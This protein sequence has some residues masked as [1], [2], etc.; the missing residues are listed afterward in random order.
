MKNM[1][2]RK[3]RKTKKNIIILIFL[4]SVIVIPSSLG[5]FKNSASITSPITAS[6]WNVSV[7]S[8]SNSS[9]QLVPNSGTASYDI[10]VT[11]SSEVDTDYSIIV[12]NIPSG[13]Q[14]KLDNNEYEPYSSTVTFSNVGTILYGDQYNYKTHI[15][16]FKANTGAT[17]VNN[18][19][20]SVDV[21]FK[22]SL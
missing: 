13:V 7:N 15:L 8:S 12:S 17:L 18:Q 5:I 3:T 10:V 16:T 20:V 22:Q 19:Q 4:L 11:S 21:E 14:V 2:T 6:S 9:M 1:K